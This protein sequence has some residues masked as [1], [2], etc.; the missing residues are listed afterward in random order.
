[1]LRCHCGSVMS[2]IPR[3]KSAE[4]SA[5][6][7]AQTSYAITIQS[8]FRRFKA[9]LRQSDLSLSPAASFAPHSQLR[10]PPP[11]RD[12]DEDGAA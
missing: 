8:D 11:P 4:R 12:L 1:M 7:S 3:D 9:L 10:T 5:T 6:L 2:D